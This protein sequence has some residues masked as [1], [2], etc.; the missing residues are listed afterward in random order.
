M[1]PKPFNVLFDAVHH[2]KYDFEDFM[3]CDV[4][5]NY[6][7]IPWSGRVIYK[8]SKKLKAYHGFLN[9]FVFEY[10]SINERVSFAY[11][12]GA[13]PHSAVAPHSASRAFYQTDLTKFF[14]SIAAPLIRHVLE[15]ACTPVSDI[16]DYT[17]RILKLVTV[18]DRLPIGFSTSPSISNA[19]LKKFD[20]ELEKFCD[21]AGLIYSRYADDII[22]SGRGRKELEGIEVVLAELLNAHAGA[23]F[24]INQSKSKLTTI[25]RKVKILGM[26]ILP[27]GNIS[28]D[29]ELKKKIEY[30]LHFF[31]K[32]RARLLELFQ[33]DME[34]GIQQLAGY[35]S[36]INA[37]DPVYL[38]KLRKKYG[39]TVIDSFLHRS[40]K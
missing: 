33:H 5:S 38:E 37:A 36:H 3:S 31:I 9:S 10:L 19:C 27:S 40:A 16:S 17:D 39:A 12:K 28:I 7:P 26:V 2:D 18:E 14:D 20:D 29:M 30:L 11:R 34:S 24:K 25:G 15:Q 4:A 6:E 22:V 21:E 23:D 32:D 35:V 8:P 13:N 1:T